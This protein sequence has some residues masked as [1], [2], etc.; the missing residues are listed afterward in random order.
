MHSGTTTSASPPTFAHSAAFALVT[1]EAPRGRSTLAFE[2]IILRRAEYSSAWTRGHAGLMDP[3]SFG[4]AL[5]PHSLVG[6]CSSSVEWARK[7][8]VLG[9][10]VGMPGVRRVPKMLFGRVRNVTD[11]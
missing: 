5:D 8:H 4:A 1:R 3:P 7:Q 10:C 9:E 11:I 2:R 6:A